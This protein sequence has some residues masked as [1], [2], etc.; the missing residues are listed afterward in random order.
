MTGI[1]GVRMWLEDFMINSSSYDE[2]YKNNFIKVRDAWNECLKEFKGCK[3]I[4][5]C[6][7][8]YTK[9]ANKVD[10]LNLDMYYAFGKGKI[11]CGISDTLDYFEDAIGELEDKALDE[12]QSS[13]KDFTI[14]LPG[15]YDNHA[16]EI[17][18]MYKIDYPEVK[19]TLDNDNFVHITGKYWDVSSF[20]EE[21]FGFNVYDKSYTDIMN[22]GV[23][24]DE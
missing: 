20:L 3:T 4:E 15:T 7:D 14:T 23:F 1:G 12:L 8:T 17:L 6:N 21:E 19:F 22:K 9:W 18:D 16:Q 11:P 10:E 2:K 24:V 13:D 5:Q